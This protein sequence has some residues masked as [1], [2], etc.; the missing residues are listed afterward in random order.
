MGHP[1]FFYV[2]S[3]LMIAGALGVIL[4]RHPIYAVLNLVV[5][6]LCLS[7]LF[8]LLGAYFVAIIQILVYAGAILVLFLFVVMLLDLAP[9]TLFQT[10]GGTLRLAGWVFGLLFL[11]ELLM[12]AG[13]SFTMR[14][15]SGPGAAPTVGTTAVIGK[16][17][18]TRYALPFEVASILLLV[19]II[20]AIVLAKRKL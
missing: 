18:F 17:L 13:S 15:P 20:G 16:L 19:G 7:G 9:E 4:V 11:S 14:V 5:A 1:I 10:K 8:V 3:T 12:A 6:L 2:L